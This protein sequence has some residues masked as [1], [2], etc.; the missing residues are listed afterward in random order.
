MTFHTAAR[1]SSHARGR[2]AFKR[3][4]R[5]RHGGVRRLRSRARIERLIAVRTPPMCI[6][7]VHLCSFYPRRC[8]AAADVVQ[9]PQLRSRVVFEPRRAE[10]VLNRA[11]GHV[12]VR[13]HDPTPT[14]VSRIPM[15]PHG[16]ENG[17]GSA[18]RNP[19]LDTLVGAT[20]PRFFAP[21]EMANHR[22]QY[23]TLRT[24]PAVKAPANAADCH[25]QSTSAFLGVAKPANSTSPTS[26]APERIAYAFFI[27]PAQLRPDNN[28]RSMH[29][30]ARDRQRN[31]GVAVLRPTVRTMTPLST[32]AAAGL[33]SRRQPHTAWCR[34]T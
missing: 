27:G 21:E 15:R 23:L 30:K 33:R 22:Q 2:P 7:M 19:D 20:V 25:I 24:T 31:P 10:I 29:P 5:I 28:V 17:R 13:V 1:A 3:V 4:A 9:D 11:A 8:S 16:T 18:F 34:S 14:C 32:K 12:T 26:P 6:P